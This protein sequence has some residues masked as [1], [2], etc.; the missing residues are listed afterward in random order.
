MESNALNRLCEAVKA[1]SVKAGSFMKWWL[2]DEASSEVY[3]AVKIV[4]FVVAGLVIVILGLIAFSYVPRQVLDAIV[5]SVGFVWAALAFWVSYL[6]VRSE[7]R[8]TAT[9]QMVRKEMYRWTGKVLEGLRLSCGLLA[10]CVSFLTVRSAYRWITTD[11]GDASFFLLGVA[12]VILWGV[13]AGL[14]RKL[15]EATLVPL[16]LQL[17][18]PE[19]LLLRTLALIFAVFG[20]SLTLAAIY[21]STWPSKFRWATERAEALGLLALGFFALAIY[22][23]NSARGK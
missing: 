11:G 13:L 14:E 16:R 22:A 9:D 10:L 19:K 23:L 15:K 2:L 12:T 17:H 21:E 18:E 20:V 4:S 8:S 7:R 5:D 3:Q 6:I 1:F